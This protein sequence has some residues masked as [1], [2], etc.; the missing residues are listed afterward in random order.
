MHINFRQQFYFKEAYIMYIL[1]GRI[2][3]VFPDSHTYNQVQLDPI[4]IRFKDNVKWC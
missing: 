2:Y 3:C 4:K 1:I